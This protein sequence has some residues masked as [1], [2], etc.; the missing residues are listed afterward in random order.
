LVEALASTTGKPAAWAPGIERV[1]T[2]PIRR[3]AIAH[4]EL[5]RT[6]TPAKE[7]GLTYDAWQLTL[8]ARFIPY[9]R[10]FESCRLLGEMNVKIETATCALCATLSAGIRRW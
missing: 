2:T 3:I 9:S 4:R 7:N 10:W 5:L 6:S 8:K 1:P